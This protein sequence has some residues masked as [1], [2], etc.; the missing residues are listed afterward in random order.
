MLFGFIPCYSSEEQD[1][2]LIMFWN[3]ENFFDY[4]DS[5]SNS[6]DY[7][8]SSFS[9]KHWTK[10]KFQAKC[11]AIS[12]TILS[13]Y[14]KYKTIPDI[15]GVAE[16]ENKWVLKQL[17]NNTLLKKLDYDIIHYESPDP[18]GIDVALLYRKSVFKE[19]YSQPCRI[20]NKDSTGQKLL[21]R[22]IL[23]AQFET[24]KSNNKIDILVNHHPSKFGGS[25]VSYWKREAAMKKLKSVT[26][27]LSAAGSE[28]IVIMGD[29]NDTPENPL[30]Q[31]ITDKFI[32]LS[33]KATGGQGTIRYK[34]NW[35]II[36]MFFVSKYLNENNP[37]MIIYQ[38]NF[39]TIRDRTYI[40]DIPFRTY[41]GPRYKG[42]VSDHR[43]IL[44]Q[45][46]LK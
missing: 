36:D 21:T 33:Y 17:I 16:V 27:S 24:I 20:V 30:F 39:L 35:E 12:K 40:G 7:E 6:A 23:L 42:G 26:D 34:G 4:H 28:N 32:N 46:K 13:L 45:L 43:P 31:L 8:F 10:K 29:F 37:K 18:R 22:D 5:G 3:L 2:L 19:I 44:L 25:S 41:S 1:S 9:K 14:D 38:P 11:N 15:V